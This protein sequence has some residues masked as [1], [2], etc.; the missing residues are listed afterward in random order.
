MKK[1]CDK[2][3]TGERALFQSRGLEIVGC[4]F[5]DGESPLKESADL[6]IMDST[7]DWK[8]PV[9]YSK[10][11]RI[12]NCRLTVNGRAGIWYTRAI[13]LKDCN[14]EAPKTFRRSEDIEIV[15]CE[16]PN[17]AETLWACKGVRL[18]GVRAK[19]DYFFMNSEDVTC[20]ALELDGNYSFDGAKNVVVTSSRLISK[21]AFWNSE[22]VT[23]KD[24]Y[25]SGEY[26]GWNARN[27]TF[28]NCTLESL[29][30]LCY[31]QNLKLINCRLINTTLAFEYSTVEADIVGT[32]DS[33]KNPT[34]GRI[35][36]DGYGEIIMEADKVDVSATEIITR[37]KQA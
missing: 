2:V 1:I 29:Q 13:S 20:N 35:C 36:A 33:V 32:V 34:S 3:L 6:F 22:N 11:I 21:D 27:L 5:A 24:S 4:T 26:L 10:N 28:I 16:M 12:K 31:V 14:I 9:W 15:N 25:I 30:G 37:G 17:A 8:Y 7:F 19:G 23:V 18:D